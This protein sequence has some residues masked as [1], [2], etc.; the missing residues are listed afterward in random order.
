MMNWAHGANGR[1]GERREP[2]PPARKTAPGA[3][4]HMVHE[5]RPEP[6]DDGQDQPTLTACISG[7]SQP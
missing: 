2:K 5:H 1:R 4:T 3:G 7:K 6:G